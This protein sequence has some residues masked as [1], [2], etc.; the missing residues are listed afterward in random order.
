MDWRVTV[1][2]SGDADT[3]SSYM[4]NNLRDLYDKRKESNEVESVEE[5]EPRQASAFLLV[6][7]G[8]R[9]VRYPPLTQTESELFRYLQRALILYVLSVLV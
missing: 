8:F 4:L 7:R 6:C 1:Q 3:V 9:N 2:V 5:D